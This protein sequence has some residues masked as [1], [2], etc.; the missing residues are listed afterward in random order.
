MGFVPVL[1]VDLVV[2]FGSSL[3][4]ALVQGRGDDPVVRAAF[5]AFFVGALLINRQ[6][7]ITKMITPRK[8]RLPSRFRTTWTYDADETD[9]GDASPSV[10]GELR[11]HQANSY[12]WGKG[13]GKSSAPIPKRF[14][15]RVSGS[16][17]GEGLVEGTWRS[18]RKHAN[19]YGHF[20]LY[21]SHAGTSLE[22]KWMGNAE[23]N[24]VRM[25]IWRWDSIDD[26]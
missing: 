26:E 14:E 6:E 23:G 11:L 22:G 5:A 20:Q 1:I 15:Y 2:A 12:I 7:A 10:E 21:L 3:L 19:Y 18:T 17:N 24:R 4:V 16:V 13:D 8:R 25:G 9:S